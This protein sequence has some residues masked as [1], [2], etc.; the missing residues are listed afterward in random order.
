MT[1]KIGTKIKE[2]REVKNITQNKMAE[3][4][5]ITEQAISRW[6]NGGGY[7]DM[8]LIPAISNFLDV[9]TDE[10]FDTDKK[11]ERL[12]ELLKKGDGIFGHWDTNSV[13]K[14]I[15]IYRDILKEF[16]NEYGVMSS[17]VTYLVHDKNPYET[18]GEEIIELSKR[19]I[20]DSPDRNL[21]I[22]Q[23]HSLA[24]AYKHMGEQDK[25]VAAIRDSE[26]VDS[27]YDAVGFSRECM[28]AF[29][30]TGDEMQLIRKDIIHYLFY[31]LCVN[32]RHFNMDM[33]DTFSVD[34]GESNEDWFAAMRHDI[35][36][37]EK[38]LKLNEVFYEDGDFLF[39]DG[40]LYTLIELAEYHMVLGESEAALEY[41]EK[42]AEVAV[43]HDTQPDAVH[44]SL[45]VK[46]RK[47]RGNHRLSNYGNLAENIRYNFSYWMINDWLLGKD[48][49]VLVPRGDARTK[50]SSYEFYAPIRDTKRFKDI[51]SRLESYAKVECDEE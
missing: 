40:E 10:L 33:Y 28:L 29:V 36:V 12:R 13:R 4:L 47:I 27:L 50:I 15:A 37:R 21:Q 32:M 18:H 46:G 9:S 38:I 22:S 14:S 44:T 31:M 17:L 5:G 51:I 16:P 48:E 43:A 11:Q 45:L 3:Y 24:Q 20:N 26:I 1:L 34:S 8:E 6:E 7:P 39:T 2:L 49:N 23:T 30:Q 25:A 35:L 42:C 41:I 19:I